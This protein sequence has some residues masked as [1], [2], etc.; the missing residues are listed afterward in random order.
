MKAQATVYSGIFAHVV[1]GLW[2]ESLADTGEQDSK[3]Y[4]S[5]AVLFTSYLEFHRWLPFMMDCN[6]N[7]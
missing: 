2:K 7:I 1:S 4:S 5:M 6:Y 3:Q